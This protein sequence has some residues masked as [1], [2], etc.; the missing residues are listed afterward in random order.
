MEGEFVNDTMHNLLYIHGAAFVFRFKRMQHFL[1][2]SSFNMRCTCVYG[3]QKSLLFQHAG[4][5]LTNTC[6]RVCVCVH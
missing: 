6:I 2:S 3:R 5:G 4:N 1:W